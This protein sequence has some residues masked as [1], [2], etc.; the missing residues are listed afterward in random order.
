[1]KRFIKNI[2]LFTI[3]IILYFFVNFLI[4]NIIIKKHPP[5]L[6]SKT[7]VM[8]DSHPMT[9]IDPQYSNI[10]NIS[11]SA[12]PYFITY[13]K[14][15][16]LYKFNKI[17]TVFLGFSF[18][19]ISAFN[20]KKFDDAFWCDEMFERIYYIVPL[21]TLTNLS[22]NIRVN[23]V[24]YAR[25]FLKNML[26]RPTVNHLTYIGSFTSKKGSQDFRKYK[27]ETVIQR[28]F[29]DRK[30]NI[31]ISSFSIQYLDSIV[32]L[33]KRENIKLILINPPIHKSYRKLIPSNFIKSYSKISKI[34]REDDVTVF[35]YSHLALPDSCFFDFDHIN[36]KGARIFSK[37]IRETP[38]Y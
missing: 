38:D 2:V 12:E 7:I 30:K 21:N 13:F 5:K 16:E 14:L 34:L 20:D 10:Q 11:Q 4:N 32:N 15:K 19:N 23:F 17:D 22:K 25:I 18:Q 33:T 35:D 37:M 26:L 6:H 9:A 8:G 3:I 24:S 31:G 1:M 27:P 28:H 29:F 36:Q